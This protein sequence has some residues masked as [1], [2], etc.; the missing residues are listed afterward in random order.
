[1]IL[2]DTNML[3]YA[4]DERAAEH[5]RALNW[6]DSRLSG[7]DRVGLPWEVMVSFVRLSTNPRMYRR[8]MTV[9][10]AWQQVR[11]WLSS[12]VAWVPAPT[13]DHGAVLSR[14]LE[15][16]GLVS[17][18]IPDAH[19]AAIAIGHGLE[20]QSHDAGFARFEGLRWSDPLRI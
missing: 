9:T 7:P 18:D 2:L 1:V 12:P 4:T 16:P 10:E 3:L 8:P 19:L 11:R 5:E 20:I 13:P 6:L 17:N 14:L 15:T